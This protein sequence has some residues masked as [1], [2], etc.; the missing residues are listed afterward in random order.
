VYVVFVSTGRDRTRSAV[1][2][3]LSI[4]ALRALCLGMYNSSTCNRHW[5]HDCTLDTVKVYDSKCC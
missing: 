3:E 4:H 2:Y 5:C 1:C